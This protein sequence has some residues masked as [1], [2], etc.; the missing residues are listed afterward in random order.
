[1]ESKDCHRPL[2]KKALA[3]L[4]YSDNSETSTSTL[5]TTK[6]VC[7]EVS[8]C[9]LTI[10]GRYSMDLNR[11]QVTIIRAEGLPLNYIQRNEKRMFITS[12]YTRSPSPTGS[13]AVAHKTRKIS[14][15]PNPTFADTFT[16]TQDWEKVA[17]SDIHFYI[18]TQ[19]VAVFPSRKQ[20]V[21][22]GHITF[23]KVNSLLKFGETIRCFLDIHKSCTP[24]V[25]A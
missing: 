21:A 24:T 9:R 10:C 1:M 4:Y 12:H 2:R 14:C 18:Y 11:L 22:Q 20:L 16:I 23:S 25:S 8:S 7:P 17:G 15:N 19:R 5:S 3:N 13:S 6:S